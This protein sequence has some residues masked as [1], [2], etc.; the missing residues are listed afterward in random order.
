MGKSSLIKY[1][2]GFFLGTQCLLC[3]MPVYSQSTYSYNSGKRGKLSHHPL[4]DS[5]ENPSNKTAKRPLLDVLI[6]LNR[7]KGVYFLF[8][9][10]TLGKVMVN[11]PVMQPDLTIEKIL[12]QVLRNSGLN[13]KK[14]DESTFVILAKRNPAKNMTENAPIAIQ[15]PSY[16]Q[17]DSIAA[18][19]TTS[20]IEGKVIAADGRVLQGVS[21]TLK[22]TNKGTSTDLGGSFALN[23]TRKDM[24][25]FSFIGYKN[26]EIPA[27]EAARNDI[28]LETSDQPLTE[29]LVT[30]MGIKN[31]VRSLGCS[32]TQNWTDRCLHNPVVI[33]KVATGQVAGVGVAVNATGPYGSSRVLIRGNASLSGNNQPLYVIDGIPYDNT[34]LGYADQWGGADLGD[35]LSNINPDDIESVVVLKGVAA[36]ALYGFR[37]GN[38]AILLSTKSGSRTRGFGIQVNDNL[39]LNSVVDDRNYQYVYGQGISGIKPLGKDVALESPGIL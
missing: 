36:S 11:S 29:V 6:E 7:T 5:T 12:D 16:D 26:K 20:S 32:A 17:Q 8:S 39:V 15:Y 34:N 28:I 13:F 14:V 30:A 10:Q 27:A 2:L 3:A 38:G 37:G 33:R 19:T 35:G 22:G 24:L 18:T 4:D 21:V 25:I 1:M 23:A 9:Q 31:K